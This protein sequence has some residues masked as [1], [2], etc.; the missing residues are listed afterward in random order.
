MSGALSFIQN[1]SSGV[2]G[3]FGWGG[4]K[5]E[6]GVGEVGVEERETSLTSSIPLSSGS[7]D[8]VSAGGEGGIEKEPAT[9]TA[10]SSSSSG[11]AIPSL[12]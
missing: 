4:K 1:Q 3:K 9:T 10:A 11:N 5:E 8:V 7:S 12:T 2:L 6:K